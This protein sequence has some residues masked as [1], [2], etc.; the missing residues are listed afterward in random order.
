M[1]TL[2]KCKIV[3]PIILSALG[4]VPLQEPQMAVQELRR[5]A[6]IG[7]VGVQIGTQAGGR[8]LDDIQFDPFWEAC[9]A[10]DLPI[11]IHPW[12]MVGSDRMSRHWLQWLV[13]MPSETALAVASM[14][15]GGVFEKHPIFGCALPTVVERFHSSWVE[16]IMAS[17]C[18]QTWWPPRVNRCRVRLWVAFGST[19]ACMMMT[20][21]DSWS[22]ASDPTECARDRM[23][24]FHWEKPF[25]VNR[26][27][28][29]NNS[30]KTN[31]N[32]YC[33]TT[34]SRSLATVP[35]S[36]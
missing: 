13:G 24:R 34:R 18:D 3:T 20:P 5:I 12:D 8:E 23:L 33:G 32:A 1:I 35:G 29:P 4:T 11:L 27:C 21:F 28:N 25:R 31:D 19:P 9:V 22:T 26:W 14:M 15:L 6:D 17:A 16:S 10:L 2:R 36:G 30:P 7:L